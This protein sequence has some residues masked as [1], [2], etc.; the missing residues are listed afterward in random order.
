M[1]EAEL[2]VSELS[3]LVNFINSG[4]AKYKTVVQELARAKDAVNKATA[5]EAKAKEAEESAKAEIASLKAQ[6]SA[7]KAKT[8]TLRAGVFTGGGSPCFCGENLL[9]GVVLDSGDRAGGSAERSCGFER[10]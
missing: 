1:Q 8:E 9:I 3:S 10:Y 4:V 5:A 6:V 2:A 7:K